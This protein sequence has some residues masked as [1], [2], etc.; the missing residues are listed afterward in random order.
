MDRVSR[1]TATA[2]VLSLTGVLLAGCSIDTVIWGPDGARVIETT[3]AL[4]ESA[5]S[6]DIGALECDGIGVDFG[7]PV[8][9]TGL[10]AGEPEHFHAPYWPEMASLDP[11]WNIN[12]EHGEPGAP[13]ERFPGDLF[14]RE[15]A[16][17]LCVVDIAWSTFGN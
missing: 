16:D 4:I 5:A 12:L 6:G 13:G 17:G 11:E 10:S 3:E 15:T 8:D 2:A 7:E 1:A 9:W 14:F